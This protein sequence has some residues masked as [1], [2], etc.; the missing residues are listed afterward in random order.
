[1]GQGDA[2]LRRDASG[3][4]RGGELA[5]PDEQLARG[6]LGERHRGDRLRR[7]PFGEHQGDAPGHD[8]GLA[9][10][11]ARFD[12]E[13]AIM[14][15]NGGAPGGVIGEWLRHGARHGAS[16]IRAAS[17]RRSVAAPRLRSQ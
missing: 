14:D 13:G 7:N 17:P 3:S 15:R 2:K 6:E 10:A 5:Y 9:R 1:M 12:Q 16:Q 8:G 11:R 4:E